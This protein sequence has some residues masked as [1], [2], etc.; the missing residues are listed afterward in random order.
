[1]VGPGSHKSREVSSPLTVLLIFSDD[2]SSEIFLCY[3]ALVLVDKILTATH[4]GL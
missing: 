2:S 3:E 4:C 1:M